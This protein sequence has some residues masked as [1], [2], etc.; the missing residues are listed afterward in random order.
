MKALALVLA[1]ISKIIDDGDGDDDLSPHLWLSLSDQ[2]ACLCGETVSLLA[3][4]A[5]R[6]LIWPVVF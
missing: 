2:K 3:S 5:L 1:L 4:S 6:P